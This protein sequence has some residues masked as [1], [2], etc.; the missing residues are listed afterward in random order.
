VREFVVSEAPLERVAALARATVEEAGGVVAQHT[1]TAT[2][3][4]ELVVEE[5]DRARLGYIGTH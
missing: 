3:F 2:E 4:D 1:E 5:G